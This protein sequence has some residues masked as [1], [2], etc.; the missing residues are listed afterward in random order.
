MGGWMAGGEVRARKVGAVLSS[1]TVEEASGPA[2]PRPF[3][4]THQPRIP[5]GVAATRSPPYDSAPRC[6]GDA[7]QG[8]RSTNRRTEKTSKPRPIQWAYSDWNAPLGGGVSLRVASSSAAS[9]P[10]ARFFGPPGSGVPPDCTQK[11]PVA[12]SG[13]HLGCQRLNWWC[14]IF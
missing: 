13:N 1:E 10:P 11:L 4:K 8:S 2:S 14:L 6:Y 12:R 7:G 9:P 5:E 3:P